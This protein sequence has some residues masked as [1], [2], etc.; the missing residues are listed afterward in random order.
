MSTAAEVL[1][2]LPVDNRFLSEKELANLPA[3]VRAQVMEEQRRT[4]ELLGVAMPDDANGSALEISPPGEAGGGEGGGGASPVAAPPST[5]PSQPAAVPAAPPGGAGEDWEQKFRT[6]DGKYRAEVPRL[7]DALRTE[8]QRVAD[9]QQQHS[10]LAAQVE[11]LQRQLAAAPKPADA[12]PP[13]TAEEEQSL[14]EMPGYVRRMANEL[15]Q[16]ATQP[17]LEQ[18]AQL[19]ANL[20]RDIKVV[21]RRTLYL[22]MDRACPDWRSINNDPAFVAWCSGAEPVSGLRYI[23]ILTRAHSSN[24]YERMLAVFNGYKATRPPVVEPPAPPAPAAS[25][26]GEN[27]G[28]PNG[29]S[30]SGLEALVMPNGGRGGAQTPPAGTPSAPEPVRRS[31]IRAHEQNVAKGVY[32]GKPADFNRVQTRIDRAYAAGLII[33]D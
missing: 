17:L 15:V 6:I 26:A 8:Q 18:I 23:D 11:Q 21:D 12:L 19:Q 20:T 3:N 4:A 2:S 25:P 28:T 10:A 24:D 33:E 30:R 32:A 14:G 22:A 5:G 16:Q 29:A 27:G 7:N 1:N 31:E 13:L 9:L